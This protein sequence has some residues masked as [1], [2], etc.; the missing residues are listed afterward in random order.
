MSIRFRL[1]Q[2][3]DD[4]AETK[5]AVQAREVELAMPDQS[6]LAANLTQFLAAVGSAMPEAARHGAGKGV[7]GRHQQHLAARLEDA[8]QLAQAGPWVGKVLQDPAAHDGV[9]VP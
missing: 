7:L 6:A 8:R 1:V 2:F 3:D 5:H 4:A 9:K